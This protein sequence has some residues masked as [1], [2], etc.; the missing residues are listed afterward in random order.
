MDWFKITPPSQ[1][2][3]AAK[4]WPFLS[5]PEL[6]ENLDR[7]EQKKIAEVLAEMRATPDA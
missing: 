1:G 2:S 4:L 5:E 7:W 3:D 6:F